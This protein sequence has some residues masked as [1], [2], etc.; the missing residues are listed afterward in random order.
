MDVDG[1]GF[2][3]SFVPLFAQLFLFGSLAL[4]LSMLLPAGR[5][6]GVL[7]GAL[8]VANY[9][10]LGLSNMNEELKPVVKLTPLYYYQGGLAMHGLNW[11]WLGGLLAVGLI[12][13][14][15]AWILFQ[16]RDIRV[17]GERSWHM[18]R[19][20]LRGKRAPA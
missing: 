12:L 10:L 7:T 11:T 15:A 8:L 1:L 3:L 6:A 4:L 9:L 17:G 16:R 5:L 19:L 13:A 14:V 18:P 20:R 2:L